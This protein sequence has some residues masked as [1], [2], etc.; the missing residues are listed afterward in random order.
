MS[1]EKAPIDPI[2]E[3][4]ERDT[5]PSPGTPTDPA[6]IVQQLFDEDEAKNLDPNIRP[7]DPRAGLQ[8]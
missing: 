5:N 8:R 6:E 1:T 2:T 4:A 3:Q 7:D